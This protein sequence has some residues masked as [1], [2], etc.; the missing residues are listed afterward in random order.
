MF[1][2]FLSKFSGNELL[3]SSRETIILSDRMSLSA[4]GPM[5]WI[6]TSSIRKVDS[7][8]YSNGR[9]LSLEMTDTGHG[10]RVARRNR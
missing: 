10:G 6:T 7:W 5:L 2:L 8:A 1:L 4:Q 9:Q 3:A